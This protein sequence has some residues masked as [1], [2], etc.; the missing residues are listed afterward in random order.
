MLDIANK[1][2]KELQELFMNTWFDEKYK[3]YY[4]NYYNEFKVDNSTYDRH[5]FIS[6]DIKGKIIGYISYNI[7]RASHIVDGL[8]II[9]FTDDKITFALDLKI[10]LKDIFEKFKF[11]KITFCVVVGNPIEKSYDKIIKKYNGEIV[12]IQRKHAKLVDGEYYDVKIYEIF[13]EDYF[14]SI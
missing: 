8:N 1:Y 10:V 11:R 12:G 4:G 13:L 14:S 3:Y 7:D 6:K 9:N 5:Q 2:E